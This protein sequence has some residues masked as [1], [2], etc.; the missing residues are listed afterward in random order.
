MPGVCERSG[1]SMHPATR[2]LAALARRTGRPELLA[3]VNETARESQR[4]ELALGAV[5]A[6]SLPR[7]GIFVDVGT[8]RGQVLRHAAR[9]APLGRH[10]AFEPIPA[11]VSELAQAFPGVDCR[12]KALAAHAERARFC[13]FRAL[14]G[15]SGLRRQPTIS[16]GRGD[17]EFITVEVS[18]LDSELEA[19][20]PDVVKIDVEGAELAVLQGGRSILSRWRPL[21]IFEHVAQA[22]ALY[23]ADSGALWDTLAELDYE[24]FSITGEGPFT[25]SRFVQGAKV[26][27]WLA[28]PARRAS[29]G[30]R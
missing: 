12:C 26:V 7:D 25:R 10:V 21:V 28:K 6:A 19:S 3:A 23:N 22:A 13:Y 9:I 18:T 29:A 17:P 16:D 11:L 1:L 5:L 4:E 14:D 2:A 20:V 24:I 15:W 8:N 30:P 27:N